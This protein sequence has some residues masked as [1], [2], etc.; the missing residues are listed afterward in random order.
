MSLT[1]EPANV[2]LLLL[3]LDVVGDHV[4]KL[5]VNASLL[6]VTLEVALEVLIQVLEGRTSVEALS[7]PVLL[8]GLGVGQVGLRE[9]RNF[10]NLEEAIL[11]N[12]LDQESTVAGLLNGDV[13]TCRE[14]RFDVAVQL[15]QLTVGGSDTVLGV[16]LRNAASAALVSG[17]V[18]IEVHLVSESAIVEVF[19]LAQVLEVGDGESETNPMMLTNVRAYNQAY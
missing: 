11:S 19:L 5:C 6:E 8:S 17:L 10:L 18:A 1:L 9:V 7:S 4:G 3:D 12:G 2:F 16:L 14:A 15:I 13:D